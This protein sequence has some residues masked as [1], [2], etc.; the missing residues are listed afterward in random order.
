M[1]IYWRI[2]HIFTYELMVEG[3]KTHHE[4]VD[5]FPRE[6]VVVSDL[7]KATGGIKDASKAKENWVYCHFLGQ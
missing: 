2:P 7:M 3:L 6:T 4:F 1:L 5:H